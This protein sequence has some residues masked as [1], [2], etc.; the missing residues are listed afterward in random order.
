MGFK[1]LDSTGSLVS[2]V[3]PNPASLNGH[4]GSRAITPDSD[5]AYVRNL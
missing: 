4:S 3:T 5:D 2:T 1:R